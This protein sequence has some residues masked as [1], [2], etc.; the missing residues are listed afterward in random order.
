MANFRNNFDF[1]LNLEIHYFI[2]WV[3]SFNLDNI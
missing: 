2:Y 1:N 3:H